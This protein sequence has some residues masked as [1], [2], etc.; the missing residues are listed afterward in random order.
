MEAQNF[1]QNHDAAAEHEGAGRLA[2]EALP[3]SRRAIP[4]ILTRKGLA[5][6]TN[7]E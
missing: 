7:Q 4:E 1:R 2:I 5:T 6:G 3:G